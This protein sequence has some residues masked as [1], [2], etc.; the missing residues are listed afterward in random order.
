MAKESTKPLIMVLDGDYWH[1]LA[2]GRELRDDLG[3]AILGV[4]RS[5]RAPLLRSRYCS[6]KCTAPAPS[7]EE[8]YG[9]KLLSLCRKYR[10]DAVVAVGYR[11]VSVLARLRAELPSGIHTCLPPDEALRVAL[12]KEK[13][14]SLAQSLGMAV[15]ND[16]TGVLNG[17]DSGEPRGGL[18]DSLSFPLFLKARHEAGRNL[19]AVVSD[20]ASFWKQYD[21]LR[22]EAPKGEV[23]VQEFIGHD[24]I[25]YG[26]AHLFVEGRA[27]LAFQHKEPRSVPRTGGSATRLETYWDPALEE[28]TRSLLRALE[29]NGVAL[30]EYKRRAGSE[31]YVLMEINPKFWASYAL[32]S[33]ARYRFASTMV[34]HA[35]GVPMPRVPNPA[36]RTFRMVFPLRELSFALR[37][38]ESESMVA[39]LWSMLWPP[40]RWDVG[41][42]TLI[43]HI[44]RLALGRIFSR[45]RR[46]G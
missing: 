1:A 14:L 31:E 36:P 15:P 18:L 7:D 27:V 30:V 46:D 24:T 12:D 10:P 22:K 32:A 4:G 5:Q 39:A 21:A 35:I 29:W 28:P 34:A 25:T 6:I 9:D 16:Y 26:S 41:P 13:T 37:N 33:T 2:V 3:A 8:A 38:R 44:L 17:M 19:I 45:Y 43:S 23:L 40:T 20:E 42:G 11:S